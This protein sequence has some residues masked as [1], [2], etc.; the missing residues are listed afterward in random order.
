MLRWFSLLGVCW[1]FA[2]SHA[3]GEVVLQMRHTAGWGGGVVAEF[4]A[5]SDGDFEFRRRT[6]AGESKNPSYETLRGR[7]DNVKL[8]A[9]V[10]DLS[11]AHPGRPANDAGEVVFEWRSNGGAQQ[12]KV[13]AAP[14][15]SPCKDLLAALDRLI[16]GS[17]RR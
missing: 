17:N 9:F 8:A 16:K 2:E 5:G 6:D 1:L 3:A 15:R 7:I 14:Y 12:H 13:F 4:K 10:Q 11:E